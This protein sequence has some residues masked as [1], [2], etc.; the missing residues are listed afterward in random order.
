MR[1]TRRVVCDRHGGCA[2][3]SS[4]R[5]KRKAHGATR[6]HRKR[7]A[8]GGARVSLSEI[9]AVCARNGDARNGQRPSAVVRQSDGLS[10]ACRRNEL[11]GESQTGRREGNCRSHT[12]T[13]EGNT[14]WATRRI[15]SNGQGG[16]PRTSR[17][18]L[19]GDA[20]GAVGACRNARAARAGF[21]EVSAVG[22]SNGDGGSTECQCARTGVGQR[23]G[24]SCARG[25]D[26]L[27]PKV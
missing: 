13:G 18:G 3:A 22:T 17:G 1:T 6:V 16:I 15:V 9:A 4:R 2:A 25:A 8:A 24:L 12:R 20:D 26:K 23:D 27:I 14:L 21:R 10:G 7:S 5:R 19:E 11:P